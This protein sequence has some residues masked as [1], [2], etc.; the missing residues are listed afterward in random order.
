[1]A[2]TSTTINDGDRLAVLRFT[3]DGDAESAVVK[4]DVSEL[5]PVPTKVRILKVDYSVADG[6]VQMFFDA[7]TDV[8]AMTLPQNH[9]NQLDFS[10]YGGLPNNAGSGVTGD[11]AFTC[12]ADTEYMVTLTVVKEY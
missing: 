1:M 2:V 11:V 10:S 8:L 7:T 9:S 4:V 3:N 5:S 12:A 6:D